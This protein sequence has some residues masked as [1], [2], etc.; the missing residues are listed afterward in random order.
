MLNYGIE[1]AKQG[2]DVLSLY[3]F[4]QIGLPK[5]LEN[6]ELSYAASILEYIDKIGMD[7]QNINI[8][9]FSRGTEFALL[10][11]IYFKRDCNLILFSPS[12]YLFSSFKGKS[13]WIVNGLPL[14]S[15]SFSWLTNLKRIL[16]K[17]K[18]LV[19]SFNEEINKQD[20]ISNYCIKSD[21]LLGNVVLFT[22]DEDLI[23]PSYDMAVQLE[24]KSKNC[25]SITTY[26]FSGAGHTFTS[27]ITDGGNLDG[28]LY[29]HIKSMEILKSS[30]N[31]WNMTIEKN[32]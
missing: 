23:W 13:S 5:Y 30:L 14:S 21:M 6:V 24:R 4:G 2:Y 22:G 15:I 28:N 19:D 7:S 20:N 12:A 27:D 25:H 10:M 18:P 1:I 17:N 26:N 31:E 11:S 32:K 16:N 3:Y 8:V 29:A 9:T